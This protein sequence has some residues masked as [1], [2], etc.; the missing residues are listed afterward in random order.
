M[1]A[2][3]IACAAA[4]GAIAPPQVTS[5]RTVAQHLWTTRQLFDTD[6]HAIVR[7]GSGP[8]EYRLAYMPCRNRG[9]IIRLMLEEARCSYELEVVGFR[10]WADGVKATTPDGKL[11][12][13]RNY[14]GRGTDLCQEGAILV[15]SP[16]SSASRVLTPRSAPPSTPCTASGSRRCEIMASVTT[17][18]TIRLLH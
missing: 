16:T 4:A 12:C 7:C 5:A 10:A 18:S 14:D 3:L 8:S 2:A 11:P 6:I 1:L 17:A 13:L 9:E 15:F